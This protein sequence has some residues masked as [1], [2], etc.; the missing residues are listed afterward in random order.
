M[1]TAVAAR[2]ALKRH[3]PLRRAYVEGRRAIRRLAA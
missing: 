3:E 2:V 1:R